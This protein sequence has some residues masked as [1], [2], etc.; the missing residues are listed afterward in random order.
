MPTFYTS[1]IDDLSK[2][3]VPDHFDSDG[4][5]DA[6]LKKLNALITPVGTKDNPAMSCQDVFNCQG[7]S[8]TAGKFRWKKYL[9]HGSV[10]VIQEQSYST[11]VKQLNRSYCHQ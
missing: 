5:I 2:I 9:L 1:L 6:L 3:E 4:V 11:E 7:T 8:F 10:R